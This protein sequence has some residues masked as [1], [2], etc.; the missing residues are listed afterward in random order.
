MPSVLTWSKVKT[1]L[2]Q[3]D[4]DAAEEKASEQIKAAQE[5]EEKIAQLRKDDEET[6]V[7]LTE[8]Q[9]YCCSLEA[10]AKVPLPEIQVED[11][12]GWLQEVAVVAKK[13]RTA[14]GVAVGT[15]FDGDPRLT[16]DLETVL[17]LLGKSAEQLEDWVYSVA[18]EGVRQVY[19]G[20]R[21]H[22]PTV[23]LWSIVRPPTG[24]PNQQ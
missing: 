10:A 4:M 21:A 15:L 24:S 19:A 17:G 12:E 1:F 7:Q 14:L 13:M 11:A 8:A 16:P 3:H 5:A 22:H 6:A 23:N 20:V 2:V 9:Q 18:F